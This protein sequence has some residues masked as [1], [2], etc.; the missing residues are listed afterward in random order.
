MGG[1]SPDSGPTHV[2][3]APHHHVASLTLPLPH[4]WHRTPVTEAALR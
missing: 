1:D 2:P 4:G 3:C